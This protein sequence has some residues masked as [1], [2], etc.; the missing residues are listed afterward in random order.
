VDTGR[1]F[2]ERFGAAREKVLSMYYQ[3]LGGIGR[4]IVI[5]EV[6]LLH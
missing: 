4:V 2:I 6:F 1:P 3:R 5:E